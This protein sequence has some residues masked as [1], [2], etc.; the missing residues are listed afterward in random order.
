M[1]ELYS[2]RIK[3]VAGE[4]EVFIYDSFPQTFRNQMFYALADVI[5]Y[6]E[7][8]G[9]HGLWNY[10]HNAFS[11]ELGVKTLG[12]SNWSGKYNIEYFVGNSSD[13][14]FLDLLDYSFSI[15]SKLKGLNSSPEL[16]EK[17]T[18]SIAEL[19]HRFKQHNLGYE[20]V[21]GEVIR[22]DNEFLHQD[23]VKPALRLLIVNG[24]E[25][26]EQEFLDAFEHR[27]KGENKDAILD[28]LK[29]FE[30]TMKTICDKMSYPYDPAKSTAKDL[31]AIL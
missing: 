11:R 30:S 17:I 23:V 4:P 16:E 18:H 31:I 12:S 20:F 15:V 1:Y 2:Q 26:A 8:I 9:S 29:A 13:E 19:N 24:F 28:A 5:D 21:N 7:T 3:N 10:L 27:R 14:D 22:K 25:G 6:L